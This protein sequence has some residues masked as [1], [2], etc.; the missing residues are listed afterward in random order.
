MGGSWVIPFVTSLTEHSV[1]TYEY[2]RQKKTTSKCLI[3][4]NTQQIGSGWKKL[5]C[6]IL[7][8]FKKTLGGWLSVLFKKKG[9]DVWILWGCVKFAI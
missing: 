5:R 4:Q 7:S 3:G 1:C 2:L 9:S 6:A 8:S